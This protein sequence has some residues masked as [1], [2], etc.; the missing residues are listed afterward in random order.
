MGSVEVKQVAQRLPLRAETSQRFDEI[1]TVTRA[2]AFRTAA[3][4]LTAASKRLEDESQRQAQY[5]EQMAVLRSNG[6]PLSRLPSND[7]LLVLHFACGESGQYYQGKGA[8]ILR[9]GESGNL[10]LP[11]QVDARQQKVLAVTI[12]RKGV[13]T[14]RFVCKPQSETT[15]LQ[16]E[17][18]LVRAKES[19]FQ[20]EL[21]NEVAREAR[22]VANLGVKVRSSHVE[23]ELYPDCVASISYAVDTHENVQEHGEDQQLAEYIN[24]GLRMMLVA[25]YEHKRSL[26]SNYAPQPLIQTPRPPA[27]YA[28]LRPLLARLKHESTV[29]TVSKR[30]EQY[31]ATLERV[32]VSFS[33][34]HT[35]LIGDQSQP[36][37][38]LQE[39][40]KIV[41]TSLK[42]YLPSG[43][44]TSI[45]VE[46]YLGPPTFGTSFIQSSY[47]NACGTI[48]C[49]Q[50]SS[51][52]DVTSF[53]EDVLAQEIAS[54]VLSLSE[55]DSPWNYVSQFPLEFQ[56]MG[57]EGQSDSLRVKCGNGVVSVLSRNLEGR[58]RSAIYNQVS[59]RA[60]LD[61]PQ[62]E[63]T[64]M[65][66]SEL[67]G[68]WF[69]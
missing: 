9:Q 32:G 20:E 68:R 44:T 18:N 43:N 54:V 22:L 60:S 66:L 11:G 42:L 21:F 39:L 23:V 17:T 27:E 50:T 64:E 69:S 19:L 63:E 55:Q 40:R 52:A 24:M 36:S 34:E 25:E 56:K 12:Q 38:A 30:L 49:A 62:Q 26:R 41:S 7:R 58:S 10:I 1:S 8:A 61:G 57:I 45:V 35:E 48:A 13:K 46:T 53:V 4:K 28:I 3:E 67:L 59:A 6:W 14:G 47:T 29:S 33:S 31:E 5:W 16:I 51:A 37:D 2:Q 15:Q 65:Q